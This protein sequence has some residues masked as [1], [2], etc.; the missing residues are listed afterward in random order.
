MGY[1]PSVFGEFA[2]VKGGYKGRG[3]RVGLEYL[4]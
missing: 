2:R 3:K 1:F 4:M